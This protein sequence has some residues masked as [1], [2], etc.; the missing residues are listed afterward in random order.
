MFQGSVYIYYHAHILYHLLLD[1]TCTLLSICSFHNK[2][3]QLN[4]IINMENPNSN[5]HHLSVCKNQ[6]ATVRLVLSADVC[7]R[8]V[9]LREIKR[10]WKIKEVRFYSS[11]EEGGERG[12]TN[13]WLPWK[14]DELLSHRHN[15]VDNKYRDYR[16]NKYSGGFVPI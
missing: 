3:I 13:H 4:V 1:S 10:H 12:F 8:P 9:K 2:A 16:Y 5:A 11:T 6:Q 14:Q 7:S 15:I